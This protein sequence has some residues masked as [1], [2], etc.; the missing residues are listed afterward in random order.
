MP[1]D[2][3]LIAAMVDAKLTPFEGKDV[4]R[5]TMAVVGA[6]DG[7]SKAMALD[8]MEIPEGTSVTIVIRGVVEEVSYKKISKD[9]P[10]LLGRKH[11]IVAGTATF[12]D[13]ALV[14]KALDEQDEKIRVAKEKAHGVERLAAADGSDPVGEAEKA[15]KARHPSKVKAEAV[16][17]P[18]PGDP[19]YVP[20]MSG[21]FVSEPFDAAKEK[22]RATRSRVPAAKKAPVPDAVK[23]AQERADKRADVVDIG[24]VRKEQAG[25]G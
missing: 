12:L 24:S 19:D 6:G 18:G 10:K 1:N 4:V 14:A 20:P 21:H 8:P 17:V 3:D 22:A 15:A 16:R 7:L 13:N 5:A 9:T 25:D 11:K 23:A 2:N